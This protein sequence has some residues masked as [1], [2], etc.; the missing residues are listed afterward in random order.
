MILLFIT[1]GVTIVHSYINWHDSQYKVGF[2]TIDN[3]HLWLVQLSTWWSP[4]GIAVREVQKQSKIPAHYQYSSSSTAGVLHNFSME[5]YNV[6]AY[7][8][9]VSNMLIRTGFVLQKRLPCSICCLAALRLIC[10]AFQIFKL[11]LQLCC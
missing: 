8:Q 5:K 1:R 2:W 11:G 4:Y 3:Y 7:L 10:S 6:K 9:H